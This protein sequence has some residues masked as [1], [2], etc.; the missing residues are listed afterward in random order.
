M[1]GV[2]SGGIAFRGTDDDGRVV[3]EVGWKWKGARGV[4]DGGWRLLERRH[5]CRRPL[6]FAITSDYKSVVVISVL[7]APLSRY[8]QIILASSSLRQRISHSLVRSKASFHL[9][10]LSSSSLL[11]LPP[12]LPLSLS[13]SLSLSLILSLFDLL[14]RHSTRV[15]DFCRDSKDLSM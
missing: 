15:F 6:I 13:L 10:P 14:C 4:E 1:H 3:V 12:S 2:I 5:L 11:S 7:M 8:M 9:R